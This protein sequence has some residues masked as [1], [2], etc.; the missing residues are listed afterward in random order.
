MVSFVSV[1]AREEEMQRRKL[2]EGNRSHV[3]SRRKVTGGRT[4][5]GVTGKGRKGTE[6]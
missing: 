6:G 1:R 5:G 2:G 3:Q 4:L